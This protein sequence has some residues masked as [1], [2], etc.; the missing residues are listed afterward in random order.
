MRIPLG[1][2]FYVDQIHSAS[3]HY[4]ANAQLI[5][6]G[7]HLADR[8]LTEVM[9]GQCFSQE[10]Y[11]VKSAVPRQL[12]RLYSAVVMACAFAFVQLAYA[13]ACSLLT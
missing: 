3:S 5:T 9:A 6:V 7:K 4:P 8:H 12:F 10:F 2:T 1:N 11:L 13:F